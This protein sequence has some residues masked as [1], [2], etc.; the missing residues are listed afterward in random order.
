M[1]S[2]GCKKIIMKMKLNEFNNDE[3]RKIQMIFEILEQHS[4]YVTVNAWNKNP[5][6]NAIKLS[7]L[8]PLNINA[9]CPILK[10]P[11]IF[12]QSWNLDRHTL[13]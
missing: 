8:K 9:S 11:A 3:N 1:S 13:F 10:H 6:L 5:S 12:I 4:S 7:N 2:E